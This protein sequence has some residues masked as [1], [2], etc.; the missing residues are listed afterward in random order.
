M[1]PKLKEKIWQK[2]V[3][4]KICYA[5]HRIAVGKIFTL[6]RMAK[7]SNA[8]LQSKRPNKLPIHNRENLILFP[9]T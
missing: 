8:K 1:L 3:A 7:K 5:K 4:N 9:M 6:Y 2:L